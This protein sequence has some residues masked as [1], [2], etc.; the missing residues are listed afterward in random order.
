[1]ALTVAGGELTVDFTGTDP[2]WRCR[3]SSTPTCPA[4]RAPT[5]ACAS[6]PPRAPSSTPA[7]RR[8]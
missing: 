8:P 6:S 1:V 7:R 2:H 4:T 5:G 3:P